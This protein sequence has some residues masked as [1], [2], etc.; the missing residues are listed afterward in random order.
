LRYERGTRKK[1]KKKK[2]RKSLID[3]IPA[4]KKTEF[5]VNKFVLKRIIE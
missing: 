2:K 1:K 3:Y 4:T 5:D